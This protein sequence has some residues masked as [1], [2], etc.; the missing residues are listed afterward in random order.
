MTKYMPYR[1]LPTPTVWSNQPQETLWGVLLCTSGTLCCV[2]MTAR[3]T[4]CSGPACQQASGLPSISPVRHTCT[5]NCTAS[6]AESPAAA[7]KTF[8]MAKHCP[9]P[10]HAQPAPRISLHQHKH[11][12][13]QGCLPDVAEGRADPCSRLELVS[14]RTMSTEETS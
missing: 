3:L 4:V 13:Q 14:H 9:P 10:L 8:E 6:T 2:A 12:T 7:A 1:V 5:C 11:Q